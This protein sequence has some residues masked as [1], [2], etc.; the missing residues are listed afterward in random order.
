MQKSLVSNKLSSL[1]F[2][3][4]HL[5]NQIRAGGGVV[6]QSFESVPKGKYKM[7]RL[8]A[9]Y[10][11]LTPKYIQCLA[12]G[13]PILSHQ[14]IVDCSNESKLLDFKNYILPSGYSILQENYLDWKTDRNVSH[15][16]QYLPFRNSTIAIGSFEN[17]FVEFWSKVCKSAGATVR[18][19]KRTEDFTPTLNG[20]FLVQEDFFCRNRAKVEF[21]NSNLPV[22]STTFIVESLICGDIVDHNASLHFKEPFEDED[23][24]D[25]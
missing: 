22:V 3:R 16:K 24:P 14:F 25:V 17:D 10:P 19:A 15:R 20:Y 4:S 13:V 11:C 6:Y 7:C 2:V 9:P 23:E 8:I 18:I 1:P 21:F 5:E 12:A